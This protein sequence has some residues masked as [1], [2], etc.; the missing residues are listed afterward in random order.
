MSKSRRKSVSKR[1]CKY[2]VKK[3]GVVKRNLVERKQE[4]EYSIFKLLLS[5]IHNNIY[6]QNGKFPF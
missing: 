4:I 2:V 1:T 5:G 3:S 6:F